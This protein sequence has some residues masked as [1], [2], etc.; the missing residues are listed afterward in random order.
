MVSTAPDVLWLLPQRI[1]V[2][3][4]VLGLVFLFLLLSCYTI[5][6]NNL[7]F[8]VAF[9]NGQAKILGDDPVDL[10]MDERKVQNTISVPFSHNH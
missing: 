2:L 5:S 7:Y 8:L 4:R 3:S 1:S 6:I 10:N 9:S